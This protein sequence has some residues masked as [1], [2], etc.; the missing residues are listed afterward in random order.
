MRIRGFLVLIASTLLIVVSPMT[1][2]AQ[3]RAGFAYY[4]LLDLPMSGQVRFIDFA[5]PVPETQVIDLPI[6][7]NWSVPTLPIL[8][9]DGVWIAY[10]P[11]IESADSVPY[12]R[13]LNIETGE[14]RDLDSGYVLDMAWSPDSHSLAIS[15]RLSVSQQFDVFIYAIESDTERNVSNDGLAHPEI[16]WSANSEKLVLSTLSCPDIEHCVS[17]IQV[18]SLDADLRQSSQNFLD[19][20]PI[21]AESCKLEWSPDNRFISF[22]LGCNAS[23]DV[24]REVFLWDTNTEQLMQLTNFTTPAYEPGGMRVSPGSYEILWYDANTL[25]ISAFYGLPTEQTMNQMT[26]IYRVNAADLQPLFD[27]YVFEWLLNPFAGQIVANRATPHDIYSQPII[28]DLSFVPGITLLTLNDTGARSEVVDINRFDLPD[29]C[30]FHWSPDGT[31]L[32]YSI[33][34]M[35]C[36]DLN[37]EQFVF[38]DAATGEYSEFTPTLP[39][40]ST[41]LL[42]VPLGWVAR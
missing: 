21:G 14:I 3:N 41:P 25:L 15:R 37:T 39:D 1:T 5:D 19:F 23:A 12:L 20:V 2:L 18:I 34:P 7:S 27:G 26:Y 13:L 38:V 6:E 35:G 11:S 42:V 8:S 17:R 36:P 31:T 29:G 32:A 22:V 33:P 4:V 16:A 28:Q 9:A 10:A 40:G 30:N 24:A